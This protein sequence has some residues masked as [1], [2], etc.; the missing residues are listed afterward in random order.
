VAIAACLVV[1]IGCRED[2]P[3][4]APDIPSESGVEGY[5]TPGPV[6]SGYLLGRDGKPYA[7]RYEVH[8]DQ[9]VIEG[10]ILLG[11]ADLMPATIEQLR[12]GSRQVP[13]GPSFGVVIDGSGRRWPGGVVP[14]EIDPSLPNPS[15][16]TQAI[17]KIEQTTPSIDLVLRSNQADYL[18][19]VPSSGCSSFVG[20]VGGMQTINLETNCTTGNAMHEITHAL[21]LWHEQ[22][23]CDRSTYV[24]II[25]A[26]VQPG[27]EHNFDQLCA[28]ATDLFEYAEGSIMHYPPTAFSI[29]GQPTIRSLRGLDNLMGQR[30]GYGST[31]IKTIND[32]YPPRITAWTTRSSLPTARKQAGAAVANGQLFVIGGATGPGTPVTK[33]EVYDP[34]NDSWI[35][36]APLP[37]ARWRLAGAATIKNIVYASGGLGPAGATNTLYAYT[38]STNKWSTKTAMPVAGGCGGGAA[39]N[40]VLYVFVGCDVNTTTSSG[41]TGYLLKYDP[42][43]GKWAARASAPSPHKFPGVTVISGK[44]YV[45]GGKNNSGLTTAL[46]VYDPAKNTWSTKA[47]LPSARY[48]L[49]AQGVGGK[50]YAIGG[51]DA[52][53]AVTSTVFV[54]DPGANSWS[55]GP[56]MPTPRATHSGLAIN[57]VIYVVGGHGSTQA[58]LGTNEAFTP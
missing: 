56:A 57:K 40:N 47:P 18:R 41:S 30:I 51:N 7:V 27:Y 58:A 14:Y 13:F 19:F 20:R 1:S 29:N 37:A 25:L 22:S 52:S 28:N 35:T 31:D 45:V 49:M 44:L 46:H 38:V 55:V 42:S 3:P 50:L 16:V 53:D 32:L 8:G 21:G 36:K 2:Y 23:R 54:Y 9:A 4:L 12:Q 48:S 5:R 17:A 11:P 15:R 33:M 24:Q 26:N 10:D 34:S 43:N 6:R 39:I